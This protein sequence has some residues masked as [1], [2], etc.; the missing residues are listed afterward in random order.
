MRLHA[1]RLINLSVSAWRA[2]AHGMG[3]WR[4][5]LIAFTFRHFVQI[6]HHLQ[7]LSRE[8]SNPIG[9]ERHPITG[10]E[11]DSLMEFIR[12]D[13]PDIDFTFWEILC[14]RGM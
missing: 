14:G 11:W 7:V 12:R 2:A 13:S 5:Q 9:L 10:R 6:L 3:E 4:P 1:A 8:R